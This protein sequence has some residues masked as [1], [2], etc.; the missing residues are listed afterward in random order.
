MRQADYNLN[1]M[2]WAERLPCVRGGVWDLDNTLYRLNEALE[3][4]FNIAIARAVT[5]A[6]VD[7]PFDEVVAMAMKSFEEHGYSGRVF[8]QDHGVDREHLHFT[9]HGL[10][11]E[12][13]IEASRET[14]RLFATLP[15]EHVLVTHGAKIWA[16]KVLRHI[17]LQDWFPEERMFAYEDY[18]F[19]S[20][21]ES[22]RAFRAALDAL[23]L[24]AREIIFVEDTERNLRIPHEL[25]FGTVLLHH[26]QPP[27]QTAP[28]VDFACASANELLEALYARSLSANLPPE[29]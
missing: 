10:I 28:Y 17:G 7:K 5:E 20:K 6:G 22:P 19:E 16:R 8:V 1:A 4:S 29:R 27:A 11:D 14:V 23:G 18:N 25:G 24:P 2:P 3:H 21:A 9:A 13:V 15:L 26:G 12:T